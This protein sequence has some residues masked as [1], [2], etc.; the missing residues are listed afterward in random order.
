MYSTTFMKLIYVDSHCSMFDHPMSMIHQRSHNI[1]Y[2]IAV[3]FACNTH[4]VSSVNV[5]LEL[6]KFLYLREVEDWQTSNL[7][8]MLV[9]FKT[10]YQ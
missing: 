1:L 3:D 10:V 7:G 9:P 6:G 2:C 8:I 5:D 4:K